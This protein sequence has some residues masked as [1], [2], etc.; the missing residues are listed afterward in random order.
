VNCYLDLI[1]GVVGF[2]LD[3]LALAQRSAWRFASVSSYAACLGGL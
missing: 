2:L 3:G 1:Q